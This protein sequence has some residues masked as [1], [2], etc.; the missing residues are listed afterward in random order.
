[1]V[2]NQPLFRHN[3]EKLRY[4]FM[5]NSPM[6]DHQIKQKTIKK[7]PYIAPSLVRYGTVTDLTAGGTG[8]ASENSSGGAKR[9]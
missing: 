6:L 7:R 8:T 5:G 3:N 4:R 1:M 9:P 2:E